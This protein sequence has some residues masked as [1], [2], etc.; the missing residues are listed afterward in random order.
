MGVQI[1]TAAITPLFVASFV[2][3]ALQYYRIDPRRRVLNLHFG[4]MIGA[5]VLIFAS[6]ALA[7]PRLPSVF[8]LLALLWLGLTLYLFRLMPPPRH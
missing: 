2:M 8:F 5:V 7:N 4:L 1:P 6:V 3:L